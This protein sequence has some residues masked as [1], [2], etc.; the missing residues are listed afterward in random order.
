MGEVESE[1]LYQHDIGVSYLRRMLQAR[2]RTYMKT[3]A[4]AE[5]AVQA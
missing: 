3:L 1:M 5:S 4:S 2:A